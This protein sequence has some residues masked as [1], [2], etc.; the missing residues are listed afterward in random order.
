MWYV[1]FTACV[2]RL[3]VDLGESTFGGA[4]I[5]ML[6]LADDLINTPSKFLVNWS[7]STVDSFGNGYLEDVSRSCSTIGIFINVVD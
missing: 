2:E 4:N 6:K 5:E 7:G 1:Y 3:F